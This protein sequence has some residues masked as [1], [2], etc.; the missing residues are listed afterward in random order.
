MQSV[1][2]AF[3]GI[4]AVNHCSFEVP[5][6]KITALIGP[7]GAG[8]STVFNLV[9]G[10]LKPDSGTIELNKETISGLEPHKIAEK[11]ISRMFQKSALFLNLSPLDNLLLAGHVSDQ[12]FWESTIS[13]TKKEKELTKQGQHLLNRINLSKKQHQP[14]RE[15]SFGQKRLV[16]LGRCLMAPHQ[17][18]MLDEPV[19]GVN[20][21]IRTEINQWLS[22]LRANGETIL[23]IEHDMNFTLSI[24]DKVVVM[25]EGH[26]IGEGTPSQI[27]KNP[28]VLEAY[29]GD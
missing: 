4:K 24:A 8:K 9:S 11:G 7:N 17:L 5:K 21:I 29:L 15:L 6:G 28:K 19:G 27:R 14:C 3:G 25:D 23:L 18:L 2:K 20:P 13:P 26:V 1:S 12:Q 22:D 10:V 16:E